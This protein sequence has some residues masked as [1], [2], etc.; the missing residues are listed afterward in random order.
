MSQLSKRLSRGLL[1]GAGLSLIVGTFTAPQVAAQTS[2]SP[3][4]PVNATVDGSGTTANLIECAWALPDPDKNWDSNPKMNGY[5]VGISPANDDAPDVKPASPPCKNPDVGIEGS[6]PKQT[7]QPSTAAKPNDP[8]AGAPIHIQV[9]PNIDDKPTLKYIELWTAVDSVNPGTKVFFKVYHPDG[10]FKVEVDGTNYTPGSVSTRCDGPAGMFNMAIVTGQIDAASAANATPLVHDSLQDW[11]Q[12]NK[13]DYYYGA[14]GLSKHQPY[15]SYKI[16]A[17]AVLPANAGQ[18][19]MTYW[20]D[21][22]P[23]TYLAKDFTSLNF[24]PMAAGQDYVIDGDVQWGSGGPTLQNQG[25]QGLTIGIAYTNLCLLVGVNNSRDCGPRGG[26][27]RV[28]HF[29]AGFGTS[30]GTV[31]HRDWIPSDDIDAVAATY[32]GEKFLDGIDSGTGPRYR[33]LCPNDLGKLDFSAHTPNTLVQG[34]FSGNVH[35]KVTASKLCPTDKGSVYFPFTD[36]NVKVDTNVVAV[37][38]EPNRMFTPQ[39]FGYLP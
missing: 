16:E 29:D 2:P 12:Q 38:G 22:L 1:I 36:T 17:T 24:G 19:T 3:T 32:P 7:S 27:K 4:V 9:L 15:G 26:P 28:D 37:V 23:M 25:N 30:N 6:R 5:V 34:T 39:A 18:S 31:E 13:K 21:V 35:I 8:P 20:I 33:T 10:S 11:C 14:F